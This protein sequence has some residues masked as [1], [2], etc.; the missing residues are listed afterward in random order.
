MSGTAR[1]PAIAAAHGAVR[2]ATTRPPRGPRP[3]AVMAFSALASCGVAVLL[4]I[5]VRSRN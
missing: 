1:Q 2:P 3:V 4:L 5:L